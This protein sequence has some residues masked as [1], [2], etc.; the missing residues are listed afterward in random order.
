LT[1][2]CW[3]RAHLLC[4]PESESRIFP[5]I[6]TQH[7]L[8]LGSSRFTL[9]A[10]EERHCCGRNISDPQ[11]SLL[12][13]AQQVCK[14]MHTRADFVLILLKHLLGLT[15]NNLEIFDIIWYPQIMQN[16]SQQYLGIYIS[17]TW[18]N[19]QGREA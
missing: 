10:Q 13:P 6:C 8:S 12:Y 15:R 7:L 4:I 11:Q 5:F 19:L 16:T 9:P 3:F 18:L 17:V 1:Q 2:W 14:E